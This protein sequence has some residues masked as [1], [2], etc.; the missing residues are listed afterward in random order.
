MTRIFK[1]SDKKRSSSI[2]KTQVGNLSPDRTVFIAMQIA[3]FSFQLRGQNS[4]LTFLNW[5]FD[6]YMV[7]CHELLK[8]LLFKKGV[9]LLYRADRPATK[10]AN[11]SAEL[12]KDDIIGTI[13]VCGYRQG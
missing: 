12:E 7:L 10:K 13:Y 5:N 11:L 1:I 3:N 9:V 4:L 2:I 6:I 8:E